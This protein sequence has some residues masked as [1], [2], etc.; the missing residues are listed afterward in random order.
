MYYP[1]TTT[2]CCLTFMQ[3]N[4]QNHVTTC[5]FRQKK[6]PYISPIFPITHACC[7]AQTVAHASMS[8]TPSMLTPMAMH[9]TRKSHAA[10]G[11]ISLMQPLKDLTSGPSKA[12]LGFLQQGPRFPATPDASPPSPC[13]QSLQTSKQRSHDCPDRIISKQK[14]YAPSPQAA[15]GKYSPNNQARKEEHQ[16][17]VFGHL[18]KRPPSSTS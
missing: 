16:P 13:N 1:A 14:Q 12:Q 17:S 9:P 15:T 3:I 11:P 18:L 2:T 8:M 5:P 10:N 7:H 6:S 4:Q